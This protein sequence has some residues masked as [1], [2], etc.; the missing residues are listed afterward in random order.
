MARRGGGGRQRPVKGFRPGKEPPQLRKQRAKRQLGE[1]SAAQERLL[2]LFAS[3]TPA[4]SRV[5]VRRWRLGLI[6][7]GTALV[8]VGVALYGWSVAA[9][10]AVHVVAAAALG[11][12]WRL[13]SQREALAAMAD[14]VGRKG[15]GSKKPSR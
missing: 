6:A 7:A 5:L 11:I 12:G 15:S 10:V 4:Q 3:R 2:E 1:T 14:L 13:H 9:G 8:V